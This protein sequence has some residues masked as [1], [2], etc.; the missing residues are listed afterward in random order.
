MSFSCV[1]N[2]GTVKAQLARA[3]A[4]L[5]RS[6]HLKAYQGAVPNRFTR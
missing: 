3:R 6:A 4:K 2:S 1:E 5:A